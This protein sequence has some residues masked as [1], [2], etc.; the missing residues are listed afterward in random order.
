VKE[1]GETTRGRPKGRCEKR[2]YGEAK[3][4]LANCVV[5][6]LW[7]NLWEWLK[8]NLSSSSAKEKNYPNVY[9][10]GRNEPVT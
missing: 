6:S 10:G 5:A 9:S 4:T 7:P 3:G 8:D 1:A 2:R